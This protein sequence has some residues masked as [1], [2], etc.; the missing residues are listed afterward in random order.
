[1]RISIVLIAQVKFIYFDS[2]SKNAVQLLCYVIYGKI[3]LMTQDAPCAARRGNGRT[4]RLFEF[5]RIQLK[6]SAEPGQAVH[7]TTTISQQV[8]LRSS[9]K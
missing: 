8:A 2:D 3:S 5:K 7:T 4:R 9:H 1:M 6:R